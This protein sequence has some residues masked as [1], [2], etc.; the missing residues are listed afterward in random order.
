MSEQK[1][2]L[3]LVQ[4]AG[5]EDI[6]A[7]LDLISR[8]R[9]SLAE[10]RGLPDIRMVMEAA[11]VAKDAAQRAA[12]LAEAKRR[13]A[14]VV[15]AAND[16]ANDA[17]AVRIEAQAKA[18]EL[19]RQMAERGER[20]ARGDSMSQAVTSLGDLGIGRM[21][22]S[23]WQH[24]ADVPE[25]VRQEYV[26]ETRA[27]RGEVS[28]AGLLRHAKA[29]VGPGGGQP[30]D[31]SGTVTVDRDSA[32][33]GRLRLAQ[34]LHRALDALPTYPPALIA[35]LEG[36][37][38][39]RFHRTARRVAQWFGYLMAEVR[40][41][42]TESRGHEAER[43]EAVYTLIYEFRGLCGDPPVVQLVELVDAIGEDDRPELLRAVRDVAR[44]LADLEG[45]LIRH[46][47]GDDAND[48][49]QEE[50]R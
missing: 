50:E 13:A 36:D 23:R 35:D 26:D 41:G 25:D 4:R 30:A 7:T 31:R 28:T 16:A 43:M 37:D 29:G 11:S 47:A 45:E 27:A 18:G 5:E 3:R 39:T 15:A 6:R 20:K 24:V 8:A 40:Q 38:R 33:A 21:E 32:A 19:L 49:E 10:A 1:P 14:E 22:A 44:W 42:T 46:G 17:A 12:K 34:E 2:D 9:H 48:L